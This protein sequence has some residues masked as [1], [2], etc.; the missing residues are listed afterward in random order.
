MLNLFLG[1]LQIGALGF[2]GGYGIIP[3]IRHITVEQYAWLRAEEFI[4]LMTISQL[5]PGPIVINS[6]TFV[7]NKIAGIGGAI[8]ATLGA[9]IPTIV[10]VLA[11]YYLYR[12]FSR[13]AVLGAI[14]D[15]ARPAVAGLM[16]AASFIIFI[17]VVFSGTEASGIALFAL[18]AA[19]FCVLRFF[20]LN[21]IYVILGGGAVGALLHVFNVI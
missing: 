3:L 17:G 1:F 8:V 11:L 15:S 4:D 5:T 2:G 10:V 16:L 7:G 20:K 13:F 14:M 12:R 18:A 19:A 9:I 21:V 6:A